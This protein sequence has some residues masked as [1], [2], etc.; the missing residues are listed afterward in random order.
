MFQD[1]REEI[2]LKIVSACG[3]WRHDTWRQDATSWLL[4]GNA[5][6]VMYAVHVAACYDSA[7]DHPS[8]RHLKVNDVEPYV[9]TTGISIRRQ[10]PE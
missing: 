5:T 7:G 10:E 9:Q 2:H 1:R 6:G 3:P 4:F 8:L